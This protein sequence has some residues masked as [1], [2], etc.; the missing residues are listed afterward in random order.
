[1]A[2]ASELEPVAPGLSLW[3]VYDPAVKAEL[4]ST[5]LSVAECTYLVDPVPLTPAALLQL[6]T[7]STVAGIV[8]TNENHHRAAADFAEKFDA[9]VY[10]DGSKPFPPGLTAVP[11]EG[12]VP[13]EIAVHSEAAGGVLIVG[14]ALINVEPYGFTFL[15][16]KYCSNVKVMRRSLPKLLDY[17]FERILFAH[18]TPILAGARRRLKQLL[19]AR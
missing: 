3:R 5:A 18:G 10:L 17:S 13:G 1:M 2:I 6:S 7:K 11:I 15:P 12:A 14:D 9:P 19:E 16:A 4:Y 8:V